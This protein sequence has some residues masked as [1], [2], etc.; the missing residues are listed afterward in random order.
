LNKVKSFSKLLALVFISTFL[1]Q[2]CSK[3]I[4]V[5]NKS[6]SSKGLKVATFD[7][8]Y[9]TIKSKIEF[10]ETN[11][12]TKATALFRFKKDS[13]I[14]F[15]LSGAMGVQGVRGIIT[16]DSV[17]IINK[18]EKQYYT[19]DFSEVSKEFKFSIDF[20]LIQAMLIGDMPKQLN[21]NSDV[22][23]SE[24][25]YVIKQ[26]IENIY[27]TNFVNQTTMKLEEVNV[28]EKETNNS[29]KL[30]YK[31]FKDINEQGLPFSI[32]ISLIHHNEFGELET[33]L[34]IEHSKAEES[35]KP[36]NFPFSIPNK[37]EAK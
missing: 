1:M 30:L 10:K 35:N 3:K 2:S 24:N 36:L 12:T 13:I 23:K 29:L 18:I 19:Y 31:N 16:Q 26:N 21:K 33:Q 17:K 37:Y 9:L 5:F 25:R 22:K 7:F 15:N 20:E 11:K 32:F 14:W 34:T 27:I 28:T 6:Q 4:F 8:D